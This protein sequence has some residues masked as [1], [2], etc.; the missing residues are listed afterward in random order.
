MNNLC[1]QTLCQLMLAMLFSSS[2]VMAS[3]LYQEAKNYHDNG[4]TAAAVIQLKNLLQQSPD[5]QQ[6]RSLLGQL[7]VEQKQ[8][9]AAQKEL[10]RALSLGADKTKLLPLLV[11]SQLQQGKVDLA[12]ETIET[13]WDQTLLPSQRWNMLGHAYIGLKKLTDAENAFYQS[14][15][16]KNNPKATYGL[17]LIARLRGSMEEALGTLESVIDAPEIRLEAYSLKANLLLELKRAQEAVDILD[18]LIS[19]DKSRIALLIPRARGYILLG[20]FDK[21]KTDIVALPTNVQEAPRVL[22]LSALIAMGEQKYEQAYNYASAILQMA[23]NSPRALLI[24]GSSRY[25][26]KDYPDALTHLKEYV[27]LVPRDPNGRRILAATQQSLKQSSAALETLQP[28]LQQSNVDPRAAA[29]AGYA[30]ISLGDW[31]KGQELLASALEKQPELSKLQNQLVLSQIMSGR[32]DTALESIESGNSHDFQSD[33]LKVIAYIQQQKF[34]QAKNFIEQRKQEQPKEPSYHI[35]DAMLYIRQGDMKNARKSYEHALEIDNQFI[36]ALLASA[37]L[38]LQEKNYEKANGRY[39]QVLAIDDNSLAALLGYAKIAELQND[40]TGMLRWLSEARDKHPNS[41]QPV[42]SIVRYHVAKKELKKARNI[43][44]AFQLD[45]PEM[46]EAKVI[47][48]STLK[49]SGKFNEAEKLVDPLLN[50]YP[51]RDLYQRLKAELRRDSKNPKEALEYSKKALEIKPENPQNQLLHIDLLLLTGGIEAAAPLAEK[52]W[53]QSQHPASAR[54]LGL[55]RLAQ[56][57]PSEAVKLLEIA[58]ESSTDALLTSALSNAYQQNNEAPKAIALLNKWLEQQPD[59]YRT[60]FLLATTYQV[61]GYYPEAIQEYEQLR[62]QQPKNPVT[63]N[64]LAWLYQ[65]SNDKRSL[66]HA[67]EALRLAPERPD[68]KDTLGW[69]LLDYGEVDEAISLLRDAA[70]GLPQMDEVQYHLA[71][72]LVKKGLHQDARKILDTLS[73][74]KGSFKKDAQSLLNQIAAK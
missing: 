41:L 64:N 29:I 22:L 11:E 13:R 44:H 2:A 6:G 52:L 56:R 40:E 74:G 61:H 42:A 26:S 38:D 23:P 62:D 35:L 69:I 9:G 63:W 73:K 65:K 48:I 17:A 57:Q 31:E 45:H 1:R 3:D 30:H 39:K 36:P 50:L 49:A 33:S 37:R 71:V 47:Y 67:R 24:A 66:D 25:I 21:A 58:S 70:K 28:M 8:Y 4:D 34:D 12:L 59:D 32:G 5:H 15:Q 7:M 16:V 27:A 10:H 68:I 51:G 54:M 43:A 53:A 46:P 18:T 19:E 55:V 20:Q 60:R 14:L 72:A